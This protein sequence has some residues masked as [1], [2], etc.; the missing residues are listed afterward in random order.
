MTRKVVTIARA[1]RDDGTRPSTDDWIRGAGPGRP[2]KRLTVEVDETLH[3]RLRVA[4]AH[5]G[6]TMSA[7]VRDLIERS[8]P[9]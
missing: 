5:R 3:R 7:L 2:F 6:C 9:E 4:A 8:C 1:P